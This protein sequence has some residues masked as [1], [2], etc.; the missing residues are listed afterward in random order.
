MS[1]QASPGGP[2]SGTGGDVHVRTEAVSGCNGR[3]QGRR[4]SRPVNDIGVH[5]VTRRFVGR[6]GSEADDSHASSI[7]R[8]AVGVGKEPYVRVLTAHVLPCCYAP[9]GADLGATLIG[10]LSWLLRYER[11]LWRSAS[12]LSRS[13]LQ[14][15]TR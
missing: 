11:R 4:R 2:S 9:S 10:G 6:S 14:L 15:R 8:I 1:S 13:Q 7:G 5:D 12:P 3:N